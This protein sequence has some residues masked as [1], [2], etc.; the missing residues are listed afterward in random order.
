MDERHR[1]VLYRPAWRLLL[2]LL[3]ICPYIYIGDWRC[4]IYDGLCTMYEGVHADTFTRARSRP[5]VM[6]PRGRRCSQLAASDVLGPRITL[7]QLVFRFTRLLVRR[8][9]TFL[10]PLNPPLA[11]CLHHSLTP[12]IPS[13]TAA[14]H[15]VIH[16]SPPSRLPS[17]ISGT[18]CSANCS[19]ACNPRRTRRTLILVCHPVRRARSGRCMNQTALYGIVDGHWI[20]RQR[21]AGK[22]IRYWKRQER[23]E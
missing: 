7:P 8:M 14:S 22:S 17:T 6:L 5:L 10:L 15:Q 23:G 21:C 20:A 2:S 9:M 3:I 18:H 16:S 12:L 19:A 1:S 4:V 11:S 13:Y